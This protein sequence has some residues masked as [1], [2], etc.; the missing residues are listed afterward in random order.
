MFEI[1]PLSNALGAEIIGLDLSQPLDDA[2]FSTVH[3]AH[4]EHMVLVFRDQQLTPEQHILFSRRFGDLSGHVFD[5]FLLPGYPEILKVSNKKR[6]DGEF[7]GLP[8]AGRRWHSDLSY[9]ATPSLGSLLY[10]LEIPPEGGDTLFNNMYRAY[11][12][13]P[14]STKV[15]LEGR[16][17]EYL[18]GSAR[19]YYTAE[20][21]PPLTPEQLAKVPP[22]HHPVV[23]THPETG[24]KALYVSHSHTVRILDMDEAESEA[25]LAELTEHSVQPEFVYR[26]K[27]RLRDLVFW[28]NRCCMHIAEPPP[29]EYGRHMHRTTVVGDRPY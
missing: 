7:A 25:L 15:R 12:T 28:D 11:E 4:L 21:R 5:Q 22:A 10:A 16:K 8:Q 23:R 14:E 17:A 27:W 9:T 2:T 19:K 26:H 24:R 29:P 3:A 1:R 20:E 13:L 6:D 18:L